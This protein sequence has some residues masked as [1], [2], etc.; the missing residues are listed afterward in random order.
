MQM[1]L[2]YI[3]PQH[4]LLVIATL[5]ITFFFMTWMDLR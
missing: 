2:Q 4:M 3:M 5:A 1:M